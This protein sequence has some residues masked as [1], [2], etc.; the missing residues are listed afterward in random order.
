M[1]AVTTWGPVKRIEMVLQQDVI[2]E[3]AKKLDA[4]GVSG[5]TL[6]Q[7]VLG[8]GERGLRTGI[9]LG[10]FEYHHLL[11][12]CEE[13]QVEPIVEMVRPYLKRFGGMCLV[14]DAQWVIH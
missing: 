12:A 3:I 13:A 4:L 7:D 1:S 9:G 8:R 11:I 14:S 10:A 2:E 6:I 5:Y